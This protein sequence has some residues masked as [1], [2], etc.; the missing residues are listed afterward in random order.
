MSS[1]DLALAPMRAAVKVQPNGSENRPFPDAEPFLPR[2]LKDRARA[3]AS[4]AAERF[5][6][7]V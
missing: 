4:Q 1:S 7:P 2:V 6:D 3:P 5:S